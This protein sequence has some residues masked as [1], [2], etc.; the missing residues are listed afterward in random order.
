[1][2]RYRLFKRKE[3]PECKER[4]FARAG[5]SRK[6][7]KRKPGKS[8]GLASSSGTR[9][10]PQQ[11]KSLDL[12]S[13]LPNDVFAHILS[14]LSIKA[15]TNLS[16][17]SKA[18]IAR[19]RSPELLRAL[20]SPFDYA[21]R[22]SLSRVASETADANEK[23]TNMWINIDQL[24]RYIATVSVVDVEFRG[25]SDRDR[26][27]FNTWARCDIRCAV[28]GAKLVSRSMKTSVLYSVNFTINPSTSESMA[29][30]CDPNGRVEL[31]NLSRGPQVIRTVT[32]DIFQSKEVALELCYRRQSNGIY[33]LLIVG[34]D[35]GISE[36]DLPL[37]PDTRGCVVGLWELDS[38]HD[39]LV[40]DQ[41]YICRSVQGNAKSDWCA[42]AQSGSTRPLYLRS[43]HNPICAPE[44]D[45]YLRCPPRHN[46]GSTYLHS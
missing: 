16:V 14:F 3:P 1:M 21:W 20:P 5:G 33:K 39:P 4:R 45:W 27:Q 30:I 28:T 44:K 32:A 37:P 12:F 19:C 35:G 11:N 31:F 6:R 24:G 40:L 36:A 15:F 9:S 7:R 29:L 18:S 22:R 10:L 26:G 42:I 25:D 23:V 13:R 34:G 2:D 17:T 38:P 46:T 41:G 8:V 43:I